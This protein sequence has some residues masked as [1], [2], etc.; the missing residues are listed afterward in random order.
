M[1]AHSAKTSLLEV[2]GCP[3]KGPTT[4]EVRLSQESQETLVALRFYSRR[5]GQRR[6]HEEHG[7]SRVAAPVLWPKQ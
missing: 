7:I 6:S 3:S 2:Q 5:V 1:P 4:C